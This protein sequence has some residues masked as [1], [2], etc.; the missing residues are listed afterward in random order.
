M[1]SQARLGF[2]AIV[3]TAGLFLAVGVGLFL[4]ASSSRS[5]S[6]SSSP[7]SVD[8][9]RPKTNPAQPSTKSKYPYPECEAI[10]ALLDKNENDPRSI[11]IVKWEERM[12][13]SSGT[14]PRLTP[15]LTFK[16]YPRITV[17]YRSRND[18]GAL[19]IKRTSF[20]FDTR[21]QV[22]PVLGP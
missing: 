1:S 15:G 12:L 10:L 6:R 18:F 8:N 14:G 7:E 2:V 13:V 4:A 22:C 17:R 11:E 19:A 9:S 20:L 21:W 5:P 16:D 3:I